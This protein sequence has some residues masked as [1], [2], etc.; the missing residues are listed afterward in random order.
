MTHMTTQDLKFDQADEQDDKKKAP[1]KAPLSTEHGLRKLSS[2]RLWPVYAASTATFLW[3]A[4]IAWAAYKTGFFASGANMPLPDLAALIAGLAAPISVFW[5]MA[6]VAQRT[7]PL[8]ERRMEIARGMKKAL[9]P[10]EAAEKKLGGVRKNLEGQVKN[11]EL[12][13]DVATQRLDNLENCF[14]EQLS[15]LFSATTDADAK[16]VSIKDTLQRERLAM[17]DLAVSLADKIAGIEKSIT[18]LKSGLGEA[19]GGAREQSAAAAELMDAHSKSIQQNAAETLDALSGVGATLEN[20]RQNLV[21]SAATSKDSVESAF[22]TVLEKMDELSARM[23]GL[24][25]SA[26]NLTGRLGEQAQ[27]LNQLA[28]KAAEDA[29]TFENIL[30]QRASGLGAVAEGAESASTK[31]IERLDQL[32]A[33]MEEQA[34]AI[35]DAAGRNTGELEQ[36]VRTMADQAELIGTV[37][38]DAVRNIR[39]AETSMDERGAGVGQLLEDTKQR[40]EAVEEQIMKQRE[41]LAQATRLSAE[42]LEGSSLAFQ[43]RSR[44]ISEA[45]SEAAAALDLGSDALGQHLETLKNTGAEARDELGRVAI[46]LQDEGEKT[47]G[48]IRLTTEMLGDAATGFGTEREKFLRDAEDTV[49]KLEIGSEKLHAGTARLDDISTSASERLSGLLGEMQ[50]ISEQT[51]SRVEGAVTSMQAVAEK[52]FSELHSR[53]A[54]TLDEAMQEISGKV[55]EAGERA[56]EAAKTVGDETERLAGRAEMFITRADQLEEKYAKNMQEDF[57]HTASLLIDSLSS[58]AFDLSKALET[59]IPDN[60]WRK[61]LEGD[62]SIFARRSVKIGNTKAR[63]MVAKRYEE[64][65]E[66][67]DHV[68][69][70][71]RDFEQLMERV[72]S[73]HGANAVSITMISSELGKLYVMLAQAMKKF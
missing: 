42:T 59:D 71:I 29:R 3:T 60:V 32:R 23:V 19:A 7:D 20:Y 16:A 22:T 57:V 26:G 41:A 37:A 36:V 4:G 51:E 44:E 17:E 15:R 61:Y 55:G 18:D 24:E 38:G 34:E 25:A 72:D 39:E 65:A 5:L 58:G 40:L 1:G 52:K 45:A 56:A 21:D 67:R 50:N 69:K 28:G 48:K 33:Q 49:A 70:Y 27:D 13:T 53:F 2:R 46:H 63:K 62:S 31:A 35:G 54:K 12:A 8:L 9:A 47:I 73:L 6:L 66:F 10:I 11:I 30:E 43:V 64:D 14:D 68:T